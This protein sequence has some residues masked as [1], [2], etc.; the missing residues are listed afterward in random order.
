MKASRM[1]ATCRS[2]S[3]KTPKGFAALNGRPRSHPHPRLA[4]WKQPTAFCKDRPDPRAHRN[5]FPLAAVDRPNPTRRSRGKVSV[6]NESIPW[7]VVFTAIRSRLREE[8]PLSTRV[9]ELAKELGLKTQEL[10]ERIQK[11]GLD[12]KFSALAS[13]DP[14]TVEQIKE[15]V[16]QSPSAK[17]VRGAV[18][19][20]APAAASVSP[21]APTVKPTARPVASAAPPAAAH[22][23]SSRDAAPGAAAAAA[24][25]SGSTTGK[26]KS[27]AVAGSVAGQAPVSSSRPVAQMVS[28]PRTVVPPARPATAGMSSATEVPSATAG[29]GPDLETAPPRSVPLSSPPLARAGGGLA[30]LRAGGGPLS[31]HTP[32]RGTGLRPGGQGHGGPSTTESRAPRPPGSGTLPSSGRDATAGVS[33]FQPLKRSDYMSS[34]GIRP[35]VQRAAPASSQPPAGQTQARR[36]GDEPLAD[37]GRREP[38]LGP[39][40]PLPPVA[41]PQAPVQRPST[42]PR[43]PSH[44]AEGKS[45]RPEKRLTKEEYFNMMRSGQ[46][47]ALQGPGGPAAGARVGPSPRGPMPGG[48]PGRD[49]HAPDPAVCPGP[50]LDLVPAGPDLVPGRHLPAV[51]PAQRPQRF[52]VARKKMIDAPRAGSARRRIEPAAVPAA[53][54]APPNAA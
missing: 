32:H 10:L 21:S 52:R 31:A 11:W 24:V 22:P 42:A 12:V 29:D 39:R 30:G 26:P 7:V 50:A 34:A 20:T 3:L 16:N 18:A 19:S 36:P 53:T 49:R 27:G 51:C 35:P 45:Q 15:R 8:L 14:S 44:G 4:L 13:L 38:P 46:L 54:S 33:G 43:P 2:H 47:G 25:S 6:S 23:S 37:A 48:M 41:A 40:R 28:P 17:E 9:H 5:R 1:P